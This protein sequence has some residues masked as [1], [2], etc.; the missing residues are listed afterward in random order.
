MDYVFFNYLV[1]GGYDG[2][3]VVWDIEIEK[4]LIRLR[5]G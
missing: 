2:E 5:K 3:I 1:I 4:M